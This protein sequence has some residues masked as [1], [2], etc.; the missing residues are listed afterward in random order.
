MR[1]IVA[2][3]LGEHHPTQINQ[4]VKVFARSQ[5]GVAHGL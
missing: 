4:H 2:S 1:F 5:P 3:D